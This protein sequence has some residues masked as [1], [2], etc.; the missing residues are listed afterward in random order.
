M[1]S[2]YQEQ[3]Q[4]L[5]EGGVDVLL[6]ETSQDLLQAKA[7][8]VGV[9]DAIEKSGKRI[10]VTIQ[11]TLEATGTMLLGTEI[12]AALTALSHPALLGCS[13]TQGF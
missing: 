3:A 11:V 2:I 7:A 4:A 12:G 8:L 1:V 5:I 9:F 6:V 10:P 13:G